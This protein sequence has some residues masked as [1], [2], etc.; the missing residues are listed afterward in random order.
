MEIDPI[1]SI[2]KARK[3]GLGASPSE[4]APQDT[5]HVSAKGLEMQKK[6]GWIEELKQMPD[7]REGVKASPSTSYPTLEIAKNILNQII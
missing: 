2:T 7:L 1:S 6:E 3:I 4:I 5:L